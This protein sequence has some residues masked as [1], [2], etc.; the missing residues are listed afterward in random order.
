MDER[1][2]RDL[3][4][5]VYAHE[6]S[7]KEFR[8]ALAATQAEPIYQVQH[9][10][11]SWWDTDEHEYRVTFL[12]KRIVYAAPVLET[13]TQAGWQPIETAPKDGTPV[14]LFARHVRATASIRIVGWW[15]PV[16]K[17]WIDSVFSPNVPQRIIPS[18]W[19]PLP[20]APESS[21]ASKE[22]QK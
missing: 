16:I 15:N 6:C 2:M 5:L 11:G 13:A 18:H 10:S 20:A 1:E 12:E 9:N 22:E 14:M 8:A 4:D 19:M 3:Y 21:V 17:C 7:F